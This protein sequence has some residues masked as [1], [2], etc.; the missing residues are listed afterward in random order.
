MARM[1][2]CLFVAVSV[3]A[4]T[5]AQEQEQQPSV[6]RGG[7]ELVRAFVTVTDKDG[8]LVTTLRQGDFELRDDGKPQPIS[9]FDASPRAIRLI[10]L[11][12]VSGSME[13]NLPLLRGG[14]LELVKYLR[15]DDRARIGTFGKDVVISPTFTRDARELLAALPAE[16]DENAPTPLW[17]ALEKAMEAFGAEES[18]ARRVVLV[19]SDGA[20]S[21]ITLTGKFV[22]QGDVI[23]RARR[24]DVMVYGVGMRPRPQRSIGTGIDG[25]RGALLSGQPDPGLAK[26]AE[27]SGG[28]YTEV[29]LGDNLGLAFAQIAEEL[30]GQ[31]LLGFEP[32]K[33][34]GKVHDIQI[35]INQ[36]GMKPRARKNYVAP[37]G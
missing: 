17:R 26:V 8:R 10:V 15:P 16:I 34:D 5:G 22:T 4:A 13:N 11:L 24:Q 20:D 29:R 25:L 30:H 1:M 27:E 37:K 19:L 28:G 21:G 9:L 23:D 7:T 3:V 2:I 18:D 32:P 36:A 6:I 35:K 33:K 12:D 31:Y 14:M